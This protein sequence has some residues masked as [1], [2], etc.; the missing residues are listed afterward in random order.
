MPFSSI[1][2]HG[3]N[4]FTHWLLPQSCFLCGDISQQPVCEDCLADLPYQQT[5]CTCC[6]RVLPAM[7][8][9]DT[10]QN[11]PPPFTHTQAIFRYAYPIDKLI[12]VAKF[13]HNL[14]ILKL[15]G[16]I[17][18]DKIS[19]GLQ[20]QERPDVLIPV[21]LHPKR[22]RERGYNQS[23]ELAKRIAKATGIPVNYTAGERCRYTKPQ[24]SLSAKERQTNL[25]G[26]FRVRQR[27]SHWKH[28]VLVD[29]VITTGATVRELAKVFL[30]AGVPQVDV[31][32]CART[33]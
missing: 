25:S 26:A 19:H 31:W 2:T 33:G 29:D 28:I 16:D 15:L 13:H 21:P 5:A 12:S 23:L 4:S 27:E 22:L 1:A 30:Q 18:G 10:C 6:A 7:G 3:F 11:E 9:C 24:I 17:M 32:C 20:I 14:A 8:E